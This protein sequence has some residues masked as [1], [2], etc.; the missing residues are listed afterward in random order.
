MPGSPEWWLWVAVFIGLL[1]FAAYLS[2][3]WPD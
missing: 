3:K 1:L 2:R